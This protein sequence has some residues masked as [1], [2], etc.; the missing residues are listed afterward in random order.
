[1]GRT[2]STS[3]LGP[4]KQVHKL[5]HVANSNSETLLQT[6]RQFSPHVIGKNGILTPM[7]FF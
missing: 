6:L 5:S 7:D 4:R 2:L 3:F 1:M